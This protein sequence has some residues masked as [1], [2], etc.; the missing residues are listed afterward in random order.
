MRTLKLSF[1]PIIQV[2]AILMNDYKSIYVLFLVFSKAILLNF[3]DGCN[4]CNTYGIVLECVI[5][6]TL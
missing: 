5:I 2:A 4:I 6:T 3:T 1:P